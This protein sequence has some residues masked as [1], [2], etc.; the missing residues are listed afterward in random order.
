MKTIFT[1]FIG[2]SRLLVKLNQLK[3]IPLSFKVIIETVN[4]VFKHRVYIADT[5]QVALAK[6]L[7]SLSH[8]IRC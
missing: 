7:M 2:K 6:N 5:I 1:N 3:L 8:T 4:Y